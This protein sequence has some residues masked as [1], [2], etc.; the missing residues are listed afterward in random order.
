MTDGFELPPDP[1]DP[2]DWLGVRNYV[3]D[4][5]ELAKKCAEQTA[6]PKQIY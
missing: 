3:E 4:L 5:K 2:Q 6:I 1:F